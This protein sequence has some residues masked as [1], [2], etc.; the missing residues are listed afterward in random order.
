MSW[1][2]TAAWR[3]KG[4]AALVVAALL[5]AGAARAQDGEGGDRAETAPISRTAPVT[6]DG[7]ALFEVRGVSGYSA[8]KRAA[9]VRQRIL[10]LA[11]ARS[12]D[13][14][15]LT[16]EEQPRESRV[17]A[18]GRV[19]MR[20]LDAD[21][22]VEGVERGLLAEVYAARIREA[23]T[24][25]RAART[26]EALLGSLWRVTV[27]TALMVF[28]VVGVRRLR[29][30]VQRR[31][32][33]RLA[34][35][36]A[37]GVT[38]E[39]FEAVRGERIRE[40]ARVALRLVWVVALLA[41]FYAYLGYALALLP[42]TRGAASQ[43]QGWVLAPLGVLGGG[44]LSELPDLIFLVVLFFVVRWALGLLRLLFAAVGRGE[45]HLGDFEP[46]WA[47]PT[48]KMIRLVVIIFA[49]VVAYPYVPGSSSDA[50]KGISV[51]LGIVLSLG[52]SSAVANI[53]AG[54][55]MIYRRAFHE[56]DMV[57]IGE[58]F[59]RVVRM[60][61]QATHLQ[62]PKNEEV[63]IPNSSILGQEVINY[64]TIAKREGLILHT[65]VGIGYETPWRQVEA[66]LALAASR[67]P[68]LMT[69]PKPFVNQLAL[70]DFAVTYEL[71]VF[72]DD[73][74]RMRRLYGELHRRVL[75]VFNE[76]GVQIMTPAYEGDPPEPKVV[77]PERWYLAPAQKE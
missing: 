6:I 44:L 19:L 71:N 17:V 20:V 14:A 23:V 8:A 52:S 5:P 49:L 54:Y 50:F 34:A 61:L 3:S 26:R 35:H 48:Y 24:S 37:G 73:P 15:A 38:A 60:R 69:E 47:D 76:Y 16:V 67:T 22:E 2:P 72:C 30:L 53:I 77:P 36:A 18:P 43:L 59:G 40:I 13:P 74:P 41:A 64:S 42:W 27:A 51:F 63:I 33:R 39:S 25:Y 62:T 46:E 9:D 21:A 75:D 56:G 10:D 7:R 70:G 28:L 31:V 11:R 57:K 12:F 66:M 29:A 65:T 68:G 58:I 1:L 45:I 4:A 32:E 55:T